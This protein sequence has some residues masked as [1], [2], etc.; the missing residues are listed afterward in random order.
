MAVTC[1]KKNGTKPVKFNTKDTQTIKLES[2]GSSSFILNKC[3]AS[4]SLLLQFLVTCTGWIGCD[5]ILK[6][7][8]YLLVYSEKYDTRAF[9]QVWLERVGCEIMAHI[10]H[11]REWYPLVFWW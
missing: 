8:F 7:V 1:A 2:L 6:A 5:K 3:D 4:S 10:Y 11:E 9:F